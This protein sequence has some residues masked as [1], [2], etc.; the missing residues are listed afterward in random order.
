MPR[1]LGVVA[2]HAQLPRILDVTAL[3]L[4]PVPGLGGLEVDGLA[5]PRPLHVP[6]TLTAVHHHQ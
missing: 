4:L 1:G 5:A 6:A 3:L 2:A